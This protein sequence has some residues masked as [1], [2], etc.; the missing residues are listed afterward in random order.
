MDYIGILKGRIEK[1]CNDVTQRDVL[2]L[3]YLLVFILSIFIAMAAVIPYAI[4]IF[5]IIFD[6]A[7]Y[8]IVSFI[9]NNTFDYNYLDESIN[10]LLNSFNNIEFLEIIFKMIVPTMITIIYIYC[11][12]NSKFWNELIFIL[13]YNISLSLIFLDKDLIGIII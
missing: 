5:N 6:Y 9:F 7:K 8:I 4:K 13:I 3:M 12:E 1:K 11:F 10:N 2:S